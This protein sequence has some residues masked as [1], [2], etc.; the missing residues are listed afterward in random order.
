NPPLMQY[1]TEYEPLH[2]EE[3]S[4]F[5]GY[6]Y[7]ALNMVAAAVRT[8]GTDRARVRDALEGLRNFTGVGGVFSFS[9]KDHN[10]LDIDSFAMM[11]VKDG[12]FTLYQEQ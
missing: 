6:A 1:T 4:A 10:G 9:P 12:K 11:T 5:G 8:G 2:T 7:D 3:A